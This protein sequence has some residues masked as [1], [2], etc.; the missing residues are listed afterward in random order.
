MTNSDW[1]AEVEDK[2]SKLSNIAPSSDLF[3]GELFGDEL[4]DIYNVAVGAGTHPEPH[5]NGK[6]VHVLILVHRIQ[7][8]LLYNF[9][10]YYFQKFC[11]E[12]NSFVAST[13]ARRAVR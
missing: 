8:F 10:H 1:Y 13:A 4:I 6:E 9:L 3:D 5:E 11:F 12:R 7:L 2:R